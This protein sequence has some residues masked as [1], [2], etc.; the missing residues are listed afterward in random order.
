[1]R[2]LR[3]L[4]MVCWCV[5]R[6][7][8][9]IRLPLSSSSRTFDDWLSSRFTLSMCLVMR[10]RTSSS[11]SSSPM[12]LTTS[13]RRS[14]PFLTFSPISMISETPTREFRMTWKILFSPSSMRLAIS[15]SPS[16]VRR[17]T[18][19]IL[20]RYIRTGSLD[21]V[22]YESVEGGSR[23]SRLLL[24]LFFF[25]FALAASRL[26]ACETESTR[27]MSSRLRRSIRSS[28]CSEVTTSGGSASF[29][30]S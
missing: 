13:L 12:S 6:V 5:L 20:R 14:L 26:R 25:A 15:T 18:E 27:S 22:V 21:F 8:S 17:E 10:L 16:R 9:A 30:S 3:F 11:D 4:S 29:T 23:L 7:F 24:R 19:P 28:I 2:S 1:M